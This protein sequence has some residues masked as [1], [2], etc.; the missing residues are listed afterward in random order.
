MKKPGAIDIE[1]NNL[2]T[3]LVREG[4][5]K[6]SGRRASM[7]VPRAV[8][9]QGGFAPGSVAFGGSSLAVL[10]LVVKIIVPSPYKANMQHT[11]GLNTACFPILQG[12]SP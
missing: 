6:V 8:N 3:G 9:K 11:R 4:G 2:R 12:S 1:G 10:D 5:R 7:S